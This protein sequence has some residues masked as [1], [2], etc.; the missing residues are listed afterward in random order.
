MGVR[1]WFR[2]VAADV[3]EQKAEVDAGRGRNDPRVEAA[4]GDDAR[5]YRKEQDRI[6][7]ALDGGEALIALVAARNTDRDDT[8]LLAVTDRRVLFA[9]DGFGVHRLD[10]VPRDQLTAV[11]AQR[12]FGFGHLT[13]TFEG[14]RRWALES[15]S[16][17]GQAEELKALLES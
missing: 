3:A 9:V 12:R 4:V 16:P 13:L 6:G 2:Q 14:G 8:G 10:E 15:I 7:E 5:S 11:E 17:A 1:D